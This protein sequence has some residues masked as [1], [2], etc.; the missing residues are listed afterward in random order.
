MRSL[1]TNLIAPT[2][3]GEIL[4]A[5]SFLDSLAGIL[6]PLVWNPIYSATVKTMPNLIFFLI[7]G[8][9]ATIT[10]LTVLVRPSKKNRDLRY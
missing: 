6:N 1:M 2:Q 8:L 4:G 5:I 9:F 10:A 7:S 3:T